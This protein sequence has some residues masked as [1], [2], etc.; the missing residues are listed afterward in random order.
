MT[1]I[2]SAP[3]MDTVTTEPCFVIHSYSRDYRFCMHFQRIRVES[4]VI[5]QNN[6]HITSGKRLIIEKIV[7][8]IKRTHMWND[9][10]GFLFEFKW[11]IFK[12]LK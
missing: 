4:Y 2:S 7:L 1:N 5:M 12:G 10:A 11:S 3:E 6:M 8:K 9:E